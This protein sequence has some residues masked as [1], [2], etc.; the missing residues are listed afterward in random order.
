[1]DIALPFNTGT[2]Q[3]QCGPKI[4]RDT[5]VRI[6]SLQCCVFGKCQWYMQYAVPSYNLNRVKTVQLTNNTIHYGKYV[7]IVF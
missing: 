7:N 4:S 2:Q 6:D 1:M 5:A 3:D